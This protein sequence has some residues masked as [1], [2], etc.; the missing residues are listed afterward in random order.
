MF[1]KDRKRS[2]ENAIPNI[3]I[4]RFNTLDLNDDNNV[5]KEEL[6][7]LMQSTGLEELEE[8]F[9]QLDQNNDDTVTK[10]EY[11]DLYE[12]VCTGD[13]KAYNQQNG[14][15]DLEEDEYTEDTV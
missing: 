8:L 13:L 1:R 14:K 7:I 3:D 6:D 5:T 2:V 10:E 11:M 15:S 4:C 9:E 12:E